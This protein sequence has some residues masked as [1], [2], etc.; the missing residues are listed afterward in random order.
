MVT[1]ETRTSVAHHHPLDSG[2]AHI[3]E[4]VLGDLELFSLFGEFDAYT[5]PALEKQLTDAVEHDRYE[6]VLD[7]SAVT[8]VDMSTL[9]VIQRV[10]KHVYRRN[11]H[12]VVA[13]TQRPVLRAIELAGLRHAIR[14]FPTLQEAVEATPSERRIG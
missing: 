3:E 9:H 11:G 4:T 7:M 5:A 13:T 1:I 2:G 6:I 8:F 10:M 12:V 14:V